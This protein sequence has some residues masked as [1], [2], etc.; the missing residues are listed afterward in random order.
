M[1]FD[2]DGGRRTE[3]D[4]SRSGAPFSPSSSGSHGGRPGGF[5]GRPAASP[6][7]PAGFSG[8]PNGFQNRPERPAAPPAPDR[9]PPRRPARP[10]ARR[11]AP[12]IFIPWDKLLP[13]IGFL[14][15]LALLFLFRKE[16]TAFLQELFVWI[17][18][19]LAIVFIFKYLLFGG[20]RR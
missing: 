4:S 6:G 11:P 8:R 19:I 18:M 17:I 7:E 2:F 13:V 12:S 16:I 5:S 20:R 15:L 1:P 10:P 14:A 9:R 3:G